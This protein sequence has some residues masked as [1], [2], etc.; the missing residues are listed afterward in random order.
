M[1]GTIGRLHCKYRIVGGST[2]AAVQARLDDMLSS[3]VAGVTDHSLDSA[4]GGEPTVYVL[5]CVRIKAL[6]HTHGSV[7]TRPAAEHLGRQFACAIVKAVALG[8]PENCITFRNQAEYVAC[9]LRDLFRGSAHQNWIYHPFRRFGLLSPSQA[10]AEVLSG[11]SV[12]LPGILAALKSFGALDEVLQA[13]SPTALEALWRQYLCAFNSTG[14]LLPLFTTAIEIADHLSLWTNSRPDR[15]Q[16]FRRWS[17]THDP[18]ADWGSRS[19]I[20]AIVVSI[21]RWFQ[22]CGL[23]AAVASMNE[24][25]S[26]MDWLDAEMLKEPLGSGRTT[27]A[28][29]SPVKK[30]ESPFPLTTARQPRVTPRQIQLTEHLAPLIPQFLAS[31]DALDS[32]HARLRLYAFLVAAHPEWGEVD[33]TAP[34]LERILSAAAALARSSTPGQAYRF[35]LQGDAASALRTLSGAS[36]R[37]V[38]ALQFAAGMGQAEVDFVAKLALPER[39]VDVE[40]PDEIECQHAGL[41]L[42]LRGVV[43]LR[44]AAACHDADYP[45]LPALLAALALRYAGENSITSDSALALFSG[46]EGTFDMLRSIWGP[47]TPEDHQ[48]F[49]SAL[50]RIMRS[51]R[52]LDPE[53]PLP[54]AEFEALPSGC[55]DLPDT[56]SAMILTSCLL[57]RGWAHPL[58]AFSNSTVAFLV[59]HFVRRPGSVSR[60]GRGLI[61]HLQ[62]SPFDI[63][64]EMA[65]YFQDVPH[66]PGLIHTCVSFHRGRV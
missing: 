33:F 29:V 30:S 13:L 32:M 36:P 51:Q 46:W 6:V 1:D 63:V 16:L 2:L 18:V 4:L 66:L 59:Q 24:L 21:L 25:P 7:A 43:N 64:L 11:N 44:L 57:L 34:L 55:L 31:R 52:I 49:H 38:A 26:D 61:V 27:P 50:V 5:R 62:P 22:E 60:C 48:R 8:N 15:Q 3:A 58:R 19:D 14:S 37:E 17:A 40:R 53:V 12:C 41:F 9:F 65:G 45:P 47:L 28:S 20:T 23:T 35:L 39:F 10:A 56:D 54:L 42:L